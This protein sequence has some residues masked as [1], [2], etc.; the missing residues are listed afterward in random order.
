MFAKVFDFRVEVDLLAF[1]RVEFVGQ[2]D[3]RASLSVA[4][5]DDLVNLLLEQIVFAGDAFKF[6]QGLRQALRRLC[7]LRVQ[8][9]QLRI[10]LLVFFPLGVE[11]GLQGRERNASGDLLLSQESLVDLGGFFEFVDGRLEGLLPRLKIGD[12]GP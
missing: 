5:G 4:I 10:G 12:L 3:D 1:E 9:I 6:G 11:L 8:V 2:A 7:V